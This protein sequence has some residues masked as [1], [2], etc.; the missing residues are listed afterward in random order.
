MVAGNPPE[1]PTVDVPVHAPPTP[2]LPYD[3]V[4]ARRAAWIRV[5]FFGLALVGAALIGHV[6]DLPEQTLCTFQLLFERPC[7]GCGMTRSIQNLAQGDVLSSLRYH[8]LGIALFGG[9]VFGLVGGIAYLVRGK[10]AFWDLLE[11]R[12]TWLAVGL[13]AGMI[14]IWVVRGF[15]VPEWSPDPIGEK[16]TPL[17]IGPG[18]PS[19]G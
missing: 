14:G 12:G 4:R 2:P 13:L 8:P 15:V 5:V 17:V 7:P 3:R 10:D 11:R 16:R 18:A 19:G 1:P 6:F 9:A